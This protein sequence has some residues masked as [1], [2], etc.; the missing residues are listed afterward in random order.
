[1]RVLHLVRALRIGG[2]ENVVVTLLN[3]LQ[4]R[5]VECYLGCLLEGGEWLGRVQPR[6]VWIG[7]SEEI[8]SVAAILG[9][10][11]YLRRHRIDL[12]H[13]HN[14]QAHLLGAPAALLART[15]LIHTKHGQN[16]PDNPRWVWLSRQLSRCSRRIVA[17][18][19]D[20]ARIVTEIERVPV[21]KVT[22]IINGI[23]LS[24]FEA[25]ADG[26]QKIRG[27]L[28]IPENAFVVGSVGRLAWEKNYELLVRAFARLW[29]QAP[30]SR[31]LLVGEG[32][33]R[34]RIA[35]QARASGVADACLLVGAQQDV[36]PWL[37]AMNVFCL[38]S[39][40]EGTSITL[41]EAVACGLPCVVTA[42][43]GN[44][45]I[46]EHGVTGL[47]VPREDETQFAAALLQLHADADLRRRLGQ[48]ARQRAA[49]R[50]AATR[51]VDEYLQLYRDVLDCRA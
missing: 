3:G 43:G 9:L 27:Q 45:E 19:G 40:T 25:G 39:L 42:A 30:G 26:G 17:V 12:L 24:R 41:L 31:L 34:S 18:S 8:G 20:I 6:G 2:L 1:M 11:R 32:P 23:D 51:M 36:A 5:G 44:A 35:E 21:R 48:A 15:P 16:W 33:Y 49:E 14:S 22:T 46:V 38:S 10:C 47:V 13:T 37:R 28:G 4:T 50:Y 29:Q 7:R